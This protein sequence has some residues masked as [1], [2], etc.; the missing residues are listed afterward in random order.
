MD[1]G[2]Q[3]SSEPNKPP[4]RENTQLSR[5]PSSPLTL[6]NPRLSIWKLVGKTAPVP[7]TESKS[8]R[9][10]ESKSQNYRFMPGLKPYRTRPFIHPVSILKQACEPLLPKTSSVSL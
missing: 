6:A 2:L 1:R 5:F 4:L 7:M 9:S 10:P 8:E 3:A